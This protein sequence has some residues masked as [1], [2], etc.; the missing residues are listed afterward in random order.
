[1]AADISIGA[2]LSVTD[3]RQVM[4]IT[5]PV[6]SRGSNYDVSP[7]GRRI[8]LSKPAGNEARLVV[9]TNWFTEVRRKIAEAKK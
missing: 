5:A 8:L 6:S 4:T 1:M 7:D 9:V 2:T 3:R